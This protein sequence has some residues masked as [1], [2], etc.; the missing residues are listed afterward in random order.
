MR[1]KGP[2]RCPQCDKFLL[3][4]VD[5]IPGVTP[6]ATRVDGTFE[7]VGPPSAFLD[8]AENVSDTKSK[9]WVQCPDGHEWV[10]EV[11]LE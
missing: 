10:V 8:E 5:K 2:F 3:G 4:S 11:E 9:M 6:I 1:I 7:W